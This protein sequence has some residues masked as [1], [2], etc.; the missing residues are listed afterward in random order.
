MAI[1]KKDDGYL[2]NPSAVV[3]SHNMRKVIRGYARGKD[4]NL[5]LMGTIPVPQ[6]K[7]K[8]SPGARQDD[9]F[10]SDEEQ[11]FSGK[12]L[13]LKGPSNNVG[14]KA[15]HCIALKSDRHYQNFAKRFIARNRLGGSSSAVVLIDFA[16]RTPGEPGMSTTYALTNR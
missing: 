2:V 13:L 1:R 16:F 11:R 15:G 9:D 4:S 3:R 5:I 7:D 6:S 10:W 8:R 14:I 12:K